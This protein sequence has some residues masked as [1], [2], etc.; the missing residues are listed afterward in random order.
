MHCVDCELAYAGENVF[1]CKCIPQCPI[2]TRSAFGLRRNWAYQNEADSPEQIQLQQMLL[3]TLVYLS[4]SE[5]RVS[6]QV[7]H[8][9]TLLNARTLR[10]CALLPTTPE[11]YNPVR[12]EFDQPGMSFE[13]SQSR[14]LRALGQW[15]PLVELLW[16]QDIKSDFDLLTRTGYT[17]TNSL[18]RL[19]HVT[20]LSRLIGKPIDDILRGYAKC[21]LLVHSTVLAGHEPRA[22]YTASAS[23]HQFRKM[24]PLELQDVCFPPYQEDNIMRL[25]TLEAAR[26]LLFGPHENNVTYVGEITNPAR[27]APLVSRL[28]H[29]VDRIGKHNPILY[30]L[31]GTK[32]PDNL[33]EDRYN[34]FRRL[35]DTTL[36]KQSELYLEQVGS[37]LDRLD[38][39]C[40]M[41]AYAKL[42]P[43]QLSGRHLLTFLRDQEYR[44][45]EVPVA[46][47]HKLLWAAR[48]LGF[49]MPL[50]T[51]LV[52]HML[53]H[54]NYNPSATTNWPDW[55]FTE[56]EALT[57][58]EEL[59]PY[60]RIRW[61]ALCCFAYGAKPLYYYI[62]AECEYQNDQKFQLRVRIAD[63]ASPAERWEVQKLGLTSNNWWK[64]LEEFWHQN[65]TSSL[66]LDMGSNDRMNFEWNNAQSPQNALSGYYS[67]MCDFRQYLWSLGYPVST[68][69]KLDV[70]AVR[71]FWPSLMTRVGI[72]F[73][74]IQQI[75]AW[76][77]DSA[78]SYDYDAARLR[79]SKIRAINDWTRQNPT[80]N[81]EDDHIGLEA[82][83]LGCII[84]TFR[85]LNTESDSDS[86]LCTTELT[87]AVEHDFT[88][89]PIPDR[90]NYAVFHQLP[91]EDPAAVFLAAID[92]TN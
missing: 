5:E 53:T 24:Y 39:W 4:R 17:A 8:G 35:V 83:Q 46:V 9:T 85:A 44:G 52:S 64:P 16:E 42:N 81:S 77:T 21:A 82:G 65:P 33:L 43:T 19:K 49:P 41:H 13:L 71:R 36:R 76:R 10:E 29:W 75:G 57:A 84:E 40:L 11:G 2:P 74:T 48:Y 25:I 51:P 92:A 91:P 56:L 59:Q 15:A 73:S 61:S 87:P 26:N 31:L 6:T 7:L 18:N 63:T 67:G 90:Q 69:M 23:I 27:I 72:P 32:P 34:E 79:R 68:T 86:V 58:K 38:N 3:N 47:M 88:Q 30:T 50:D 80:L 12:I 45:A 14:M 54:T 20:G 37:E 70:T 1:P 22:D 28:L 60:E 62:G 78:I 89:L 55:V 66:P